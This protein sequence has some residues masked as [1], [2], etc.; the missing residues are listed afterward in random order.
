MLDVLPGFLLYAKLI[1]QRLLADAGQERHPDKLGSAALFLSEGI[2]RGF[3]S[4]HHFHAAL[5][6]YGEEVHAQIAGRE[7][8]PLHRVGYVVVL[9]V[10]E[11][12]SA[13]DPNKIED[14]RAEPGEL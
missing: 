4:P 14:R 1:F 2:S 13:A 10:K 9:Q 12:F 5:G 11:Y 7:N 3:C 8:R 6:V